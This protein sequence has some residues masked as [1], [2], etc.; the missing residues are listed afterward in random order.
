MKRLARLLAVPF[1]W[2]W[3][4]RRFVIGLAAFGSIAAGF[5][6]AW[7]PLGLIVPGA[8]IFGA[9][10]YSRVSGRDAPKPIPTH[11]EQS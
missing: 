5:W 7:E 1:V 8:I 2:L 4:A 10:V 6:M 9:L 11:D 3:Q